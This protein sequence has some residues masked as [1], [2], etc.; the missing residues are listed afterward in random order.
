MASSQPVD[1]RDQETRNVLIRGLMRR[2]S[3][4]LA[5]NVTPDKQVAWAETMADLLIEKANQCALRHFLDHSEH[6]I[7]LSPSDEECAALNETLGQTWAYGKAEYHGRS[8]AVRAS[9]VL[10]MHILR[11]MGREDA[12]WEREKN[13][14][15]APGPGVRG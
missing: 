6:F 7:S 10:W 5:K 8:W 1:L 3:V 9:G 14:G 12:E 2:Y 11:L 4:W 13:S 15:P